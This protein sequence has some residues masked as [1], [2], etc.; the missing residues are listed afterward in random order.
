MHT[1]HVPLADLRKMGSKQKHLTSY[2]LLDSTVVRKSWKLQTRTQGSTGAGS[3]SVPRLSKPSRM[4]KH[5]PQLCYLFLAKALLRESKLSLNLFLIRISA[6]TK[7]PQTTGQQSF[8][9]RL[10]LEGKKRWFLLSQALHSLPFQYGWQN[11]PSGAPKLH[12]W[13]NVAPNC[14]HILTVPSPQQ[15]WLVGKHREAC[16]SLQLSEH[17]S[18]VAH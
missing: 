15:C 18:H 1:H 11:Y 10:V 3:P 5:N 6:T 16:G 8:Y 12:R 2:Y 17:N 7:A 9:L 14:Q 4:L 13:I